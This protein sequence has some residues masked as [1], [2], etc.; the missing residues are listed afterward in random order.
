MVVCVKFT[1]F[2]TVVNN[3]VLKKKAGRAPDYFVCQ[4]TAIVYGEV[5]EWLTKCEGI[6]DAEGGPQDRA[7]QL[8][9]AS[10]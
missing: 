4:K 10:H 7:T 1:P 8:S 3:A 5:S 6:L 2:K 9:V